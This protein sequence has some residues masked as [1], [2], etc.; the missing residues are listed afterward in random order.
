MQPQYKAL[1]LG[2]NLN[3]EWEK[4][5]CLDITRLTLVVEAYLPLT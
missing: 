2:Y 4:T 3:E 5:K 1:F